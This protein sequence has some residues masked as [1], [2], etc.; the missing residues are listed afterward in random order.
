MTI[1]FACASVFIYVTMKPYT[2]KLTDG[3]FDCQ[4]LASPRFSGYLPMLLTQLVYTA[5]HSEFD[6]GLSLAESVHTILKLSLFVLNAKCK[7]TT[8]VL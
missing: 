5:L 6:L 2:W 4:V 1:S 7:T 3:R 8:P